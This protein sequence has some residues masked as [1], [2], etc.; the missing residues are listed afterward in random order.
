MKMK[1]A[2][3]EDQQTGTTKSVPYHTG[4]SEIH[5]DQYSNNFIVIVVGESGSDCSFRNNYSERLSGKKESSYLGKVIAF[6]RKEHTDHSI[7]SPPFHVA[8]SCNIPSRRTSTIYDRADHSI[9]FQLVFQYIIVEKL[10]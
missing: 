10:A 5:S 6:N 9:Q 8:V 1:T 2:F 7:P 3:L 4:R